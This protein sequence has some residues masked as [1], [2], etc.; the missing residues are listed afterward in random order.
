MP[1]PN[2]RPVTMHVAG[3]PGAAVV[4]D[5]AGRP[6]AFIDDA[7][8]PPPGRGRVPLYGPLRHQDRAVL[9]RPKRPEPWA[10]QIPKGS[11]HG[12]MLLEAFQ[13]HG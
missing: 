3:L 12:K 6:T 11:S 2:P 13:G 8:R 1:L 10:G 9:L 7:G 4:A 5:A